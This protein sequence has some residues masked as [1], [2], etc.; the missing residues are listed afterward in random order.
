MMTPP[1]REAPPLGRGASLFFIDSQ[2]NLDNSVPLAYKNIYD[3]G[4]SIQDIADL[5]GGYCGKTI[6]RHA[7]CQKEIFA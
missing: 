1:C 6:R 5:K 3:F 7:G 4:Y 2:K